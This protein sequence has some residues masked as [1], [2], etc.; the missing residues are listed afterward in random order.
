[1]RGEV[2][3]GPGIALPQIPDKPSYTVTTTLNPGDNIQAAIDAANTGDVIQLNN[4]TYSLSANLNINKSVYLVGQSQAGVIVQDTRG[5]AQ[6]F[7]N[8]SADNVLLENLTIRQVTSDT[9]IGTAITVSGTGFPNTTRIDNFRMYGVT[10]QYSK[11]GLSIRS[12]DYVVQGN[13]FQLIAGSSGT[14]R[15]LLVY[16][17]GGDAFIANNTF[18]NNLAGTTLRAVVLTST[19]GNNTGDNLAGSLTIQGSTFPG[20]VALSQFVS[21]D[22]FQGAAGAF[23]LI[24][25]GNVTNETNAF[26]VAV[27]GAQNFGNVFNRVVLINNTL[28]NSHGS[29]GGKGVFGIDGSG[30]PLAF[31]SSSLP[32]FASGNALGQLVFRTGWAQANGSTGSTVGYSTTQIAQPT[33]GMTAAEPAVRYLDTATNVVISPAG[34]DSAANVGNSPQQIVVTTDGTRSYYSANGSSQVRMIDLATDTV[35]AIIGGVG[36]SPRGLAARPDGSAVYVVSD[37]GVSVID[38][39]PGSGGYNSVVGTIAI[40]GNGQDV[41]FSPD[42]KWAYVTN[43]GVT[44]QG[45][46][47]QVL[48]IDTDPASGSCNTVFRTIGLG[49]GEKPSAVAIS[50]DGSTLYVTSNPG[51]PGKVWAIG[52]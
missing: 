50:P 33:V 44:N 1:V 36:A 32:V 18:V 49:V 23:D 52:V 28:T 48:V 13:T 14:R 15:G 26:V 2:Q 8:V 3:R 6:N 16:G 35:G 45:V 19:T 11:A 51:N 31:R 42:G 7:V 30:G 38:S 17:N 25:N 9:N 10:V 22:N 46:A 47:G 39:N 37:T 41:V 34:L 43:Q 4:G 21:M 5:N 27:G 20:S 29:G 40:G 12:N 24:V